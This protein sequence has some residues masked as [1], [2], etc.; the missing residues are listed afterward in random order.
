MFR[1]KQLMPIIH[2]YNVS[3]SANRSLFWP[4]CWNKKK[5]KINLSIIAF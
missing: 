3:F 5:R 4:L 2:V 1:G